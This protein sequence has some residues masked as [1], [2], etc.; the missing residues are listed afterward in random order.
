MEPFMDLLKKDV[1]WVWV[2]TFQTTFDKLE[3]TF[4]L[5]PMLRLPHFEKHF[6]VNPNALDKVISGVLA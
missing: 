4:A 5:E 6:E 3:L 2:E 1:K